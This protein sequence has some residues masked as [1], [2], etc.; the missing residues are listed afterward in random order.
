MSE[1]NKPSS[2][3]SKN[4]QDSVDKNSARLTD[5]KKK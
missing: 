1:K 4:V 5:T 3:S 2:S